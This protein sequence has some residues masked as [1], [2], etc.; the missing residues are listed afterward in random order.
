MSFQMN[1][2][3]GGD[4]SGLEENNEINVTPLIDVML[5]ILIVFMVAAPLATVDTPV[6]LPASNAPQSD[7]PDE[8]VWLTYTAGGDLRLDDELV[9]MT[10]LAP[11]LDGRTQG[12]KETRIYLQ[13]DESVSYGSVTN[14]LNVLRSAGYL[15]VAL[16]GMEDPTI[17]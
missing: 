7:R 10:G 16:V 4:G 8:P 1:S 2:A 12:D 9:V 17:Q 14:V 13:A 15:K 5:V 11:L 6:D 3:P